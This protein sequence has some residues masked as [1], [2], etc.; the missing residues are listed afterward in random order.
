MG[1]AVQDFNA[2]V[3]AAIEAARTLGG[4]EGAAARGEIKEPSPTGRE[5]PPVKAL[6][7]KPEGLE[8]GLDK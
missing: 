4:M 2:I 7:G 1:L 5:K 3:S 8:L 6:L